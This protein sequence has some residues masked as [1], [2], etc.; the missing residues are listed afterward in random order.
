MKGEKELESVE[1]TDIFI[2]TWNF[3]IPRENK[4]FVMLAGTK[5]WKVQLLK[6][7]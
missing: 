4:W 3:L 6:S 2:G 5:L 1:N 7:F